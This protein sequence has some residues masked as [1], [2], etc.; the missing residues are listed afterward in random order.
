[1]HGLI[2]DRE[3]EKLSI[4]WLSRRPMRKEGM[5]GM[6]TGHLENRQPQVADTVFCLYFARDSQGE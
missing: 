4:R 2:I 3:T 1:M 6:K 5:N